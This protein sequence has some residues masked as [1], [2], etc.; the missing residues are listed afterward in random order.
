[1]ALEEYDYLMVDSEDFWG[2]DSSTFND[3]TNWYGKVFVVSKQK[4]EENPNL[5]QELNLMPCAMF[6]LIGAE[7][8]QRFRPTRIQVD[9][10]RMVAVIEG[11]QKRIGQ[12]TEDV[13]RPMLF[14]LNGLAPRGSYCPSAVILPKLRPSPLG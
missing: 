13:V 12:D 11:V 7:D 8:S 1:M 9:E 6:F 14:R 2:Y 5:I 10:E 4:I 3:K